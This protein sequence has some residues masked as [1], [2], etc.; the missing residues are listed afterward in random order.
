MAF[1]SMLIVAPNGIENDDTS[2]ETPSS[3]NFSNVNGI[4]AFDDVDENELQYNRSLQ[5]RILSG[6]L[7]LA[8]NGLTLKLNPSA[9]DAFKLM[10][11]PLGEIYNSIFAGFTFI[12]DTAITQIAESTGNQVAL[13]TKEMLNIYKPANPTKLDT[14]KSLINLVPY[15]AIVQRFITGA[16]YA[17]EIGNILPAI[18]PSVFGRTKQFET[19]TFNNTRSYSKYSYGKRK[20]RKIY[21]RKTYPRKIYS[22][23]PYNRSD[24]Y[25]INF[26]QIY[27]DGMYSVPNI[28]TYT[29]KANRYYHFSKLNNLPTV[30][31]Y[32]KLYNSRGKPRWDSMLQNVTPQ[33]LKYIIKNTIHYK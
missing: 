27:I 26:K 23:K 7:Q 29:A 31:I 8:D 22:K 16:K 33:N 20:S 28:S 9:S 10:T 32:D 14:I 24:Y 15:G 12:T 5:Y 1:P 18:A 6:N 2:L 3:D 19:K 17:K 11:N 25:P 30:S 13:A 21:S 4:V